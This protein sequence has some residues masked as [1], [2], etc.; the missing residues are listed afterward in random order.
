M[1]AA[2]RFQNLRLHY[3]EGSKRAGLELNE[4]LTTSDLAKFA[5]GADRPGDAANYESLPTQWT[6]FLTPTT[7]KDFKPKYMSDARAR[8]P[9][10]S[11]T[12][13]ADRLPDGAGPG[14]HGVPDP[15]QE[16]RSPL[17]LLVRGVQVN[18][19]LEQLMMVPDAL[20]QMA[21]S[22]PRTTAACGC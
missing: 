10:S 2:A 12:S 22:T 16:D 19:D 1:E 4:A 14:A 5:S 6:K 8:R 3:L 20:P 11:R 17:G 15:G 18:D 9:R 21:K 13:R 7:V